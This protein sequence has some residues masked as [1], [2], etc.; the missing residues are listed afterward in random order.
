[1]YNG[2]L[3][4]QCHEKSDFLNGYTQKEHRFEIYADISKLF[5]WYVGIEI[6]NLKDSMRLMQKT[7]LFPVQIG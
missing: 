3:K 2:V 7:Y 1:M 5:F 6:L 4:G